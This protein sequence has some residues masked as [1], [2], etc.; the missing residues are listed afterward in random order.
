MQILHIL[1]TTIELDS[2]NNNLEGESWQGDFFQKWW[3]QKSD[4]N[5][6]VGYSEINL[7]VMS[8]FVI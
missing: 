2:H 6:R 5:E 3:T 4:Q 1:I 8:Y 7:Y